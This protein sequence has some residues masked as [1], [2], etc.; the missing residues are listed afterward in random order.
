MDTMVFYPIDTTLME[1]VEPIRIAS[2]PKRK[3]VIYVAGKYRDN[4]GEWYVECHIREAEKA[5][6]FIWMNGG[7]AI[8]PHLNTRHFGGLCPDSVWLEGDLEILSRC[9][10][11]YMCSNWGDSKGACQEQ[12][13]AMSLGIRILYD[14][15]ELLH[16]L[17]VIR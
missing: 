9:D 17:E 11:I 15:A 1:Q 10:A 6:Q 2:M 5:A 16:Y 7:V 12:K 4:R 8:C 14:Q 13:H 3:K